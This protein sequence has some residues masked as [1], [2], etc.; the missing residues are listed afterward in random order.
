MFHFL[1][2]CSTLPPRTSTEVFFSRMKLFC[3]AIVPTSLTLVP[4]GVEV[5]WIIGMFFRVRNDKW[6]D[7]HYRICLCTWPIGPYTG[8]RPKHSVWPIHDCTVCIG[9]CESFLGNRNLSLVPGSLP[10]PWGELGLG[11]G[12]G[13]RVGTRLLPTSVLLYFIKHVISDKGNMF[14][15]VCL[16]L[17]THSSLK[18]FTN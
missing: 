2:R 12:S 5:L 1:T 10:P 16:Y 17:Y 3:T 13:G 6:K 4:G 7:N 14:S 8:V 15:V 11:S 9:G 18:W